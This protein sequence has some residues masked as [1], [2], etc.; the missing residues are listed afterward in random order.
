MSFFRSGNQA[1]VAAQLVAVRERPPYSRDALDRLGVMGLHCGSGANLHAAWL[2]TD[3][4]A[5]VGDRRGRSVRGRIVACG[6]AYYLEHD[7]ARPFP[8]ADVSVARI[9]AEHFIEHLKAQDAIAWLGEM[10]RLLVPGGVL[11]VSTPDLEKYVRAYEES[12]AKNAKDAAAEGG[13][14]HFARGLAQ[15]EPG[16]GGFFEEHRRRLEAMGIKNVP[17]RRAWLVNQIFY[18]W[19]HRWIYDR[20]EIVHA[21]GQAGFSPGDV[22]FA[23]FRRGVDQLMAELD[24]P[25]RNDESL[26]VEMVKGS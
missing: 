14:A 12:T 20:E 8:L 26:Y 13:Q 7:A 24:L 11:R 2:N 15:N 3:V 19:G 21:A 16:P 25:V 1:I 4:V 18:G 17:A 22:H 10:R 23:S 6:A 5:L 9:L